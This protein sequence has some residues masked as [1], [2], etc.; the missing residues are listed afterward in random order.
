MNTFCLRRSQPSTIP[1]GFYRSL[2]LA[3]VA[4]FLATKSRPR[5]LDLGPARAATVAYLSTYRPRI[6]IEDLTSAIIDSRER[7]AAPDPLLSLTEMTDRRPFDLIFAWDLCNY[8]SVSGV[9]ALGRYLRSVSSPRT[10]LF[11][12]FWN[13]IEM[14]ELPLHMHIGKENTLVY[15]PRSAVMTVGPRYSK[16]QILEMIPH[17][18]IARS[19][20]ARNGMEEHIFTTRDFSVES[21]ADDNV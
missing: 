1:A 15:E 2:G 11:G 17:L 8:L 14:P 5:V 4:E 16:R 18:Q 6:Q 12:S 20:L 3:S 9:E 10:I 21:S 13:T 19:F 7:T